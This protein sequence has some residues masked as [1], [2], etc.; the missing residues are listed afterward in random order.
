MLQQLV[1]NSEEA[2]RSLQLRLEHLSIGEIDGE[3]VDK[4]VSQIRGAIDRLTQIKKLPED[5]TRKLLMIFQTTSV[6]EFNDKGNQ[7]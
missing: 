5:L 4:A 2:A 7:S 3:N 1:S 6:P